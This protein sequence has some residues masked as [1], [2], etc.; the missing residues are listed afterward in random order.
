MG[1]KGGRKLEIV[2]GSVAEGLQGRSDFQEGC[3]VE[4]GAR[5]V[6]GLGTD[7][8]KDGTAEE[9]SRRRF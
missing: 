2:F 6:T 9:K 8:F 7:K 3:E 4:K 1:F 5:L